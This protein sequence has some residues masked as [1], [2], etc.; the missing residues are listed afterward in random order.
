MFQCVSDN[1]VFVADFGL[2]IDLGEGESAE[3][4]KYGLHV[5][6]EKVH[7][8]QS[9]VYSLGVVLF[10]ILSLDDLS[11]DTLYAHNTTTLVT[12]RKAVAAEAKLLTGR[13]GEMASVVEAM[14]EIVPE[15]RISALSARNAFQAQ[16]AKLPREGIVCSRC[17]RLTS[18]CTECRIDRLVELLWPAE[19]AA[20]AKL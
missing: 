10:E 14:V 18:G 12:H 19:P 17:K 8:E 13:Y 1:W 16:L 4:V 9:D 5:A 20:G 11:H 6:P 3:R 15:K 7:S 2:C